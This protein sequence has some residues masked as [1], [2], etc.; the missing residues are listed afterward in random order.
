MVWSVVA[1]VGDIAVGVFSTVQHTSWGSNE[2]THLL[3]KFQPKKNFLA[4][5]LPSDYKEKH[6]S[7]RTYCWKNAP[8]AQKRM[9]GFGRLSRMGTDVQTGG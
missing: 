2:N 5:L 4:L 8:G 3:I 6:A 7:W 9:C 1:I